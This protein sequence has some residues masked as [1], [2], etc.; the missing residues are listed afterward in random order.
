[1][2][3][4]ITIRR[5][6]RNGSFYFGKRVARNVGYRG[7]IQTYFGGSSEQA[8]ASILRGKRFA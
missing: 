5:R 3:G 4:R 6:H 1:M 7:Q 8:H 2:E